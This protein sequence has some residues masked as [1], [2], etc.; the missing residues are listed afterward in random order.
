MIFTNINKV[1]F[2]NV[3][4]IYK[5][6]IKCSKMLRYICNDVQDDVQDF[7]FGYIYVF[8]PEINLIYKYSL[9]R[10]DTRDKNRRF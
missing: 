3:E 4:I 9:L 2:G 10:D 5:C 1:H 6:D 8:L 7:I